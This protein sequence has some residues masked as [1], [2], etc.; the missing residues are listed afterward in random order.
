MGKILFTVLFCISAL[1]VQNDD[2]YATIKGKL[3]PS[4][5]LSADSVYLFILQE[6]EYALA[7]SCAIDENRM[8]SLRACGKMSPDVNAYLIVPPRSYL[9]ELGQGEDIYIEIDSETR[10]SHPFAQ[11]ASINN[12][13]AHRIETAKEILARKADLEDS[14]AAPGLSE[15]EIQALRR[16]WEALEYE[17][18]VGQHLK[19]AAVTR[20]PVSY[21]AIISVLSGETGG[22]PRISES[23]VDSL[24]RD[25]KQRFPDNRR[26]QQYPDAQPSP[27]ASE[28]S[29]RAFL[30]MRE[31]TSRNP[32]N[33]G[34]SEHTA[35]ATA[36]IVPYRVSDLVSPFTLAGLNE[37]HVSLDSLTTDYV[38]IDFW[39]GWCIPCRLEVPHLK[40]VL[41]K[42]GDH[43][44]IYAISL[45]NSLGAWKSAIR[46][47]RSEMFTHVYLGN[48]N[49]EAAA[50][51]LKQFGITAIPA[52][53][54]LDKDRRIIA[55][56]LR[57]EALERK[58]EGFCIIGIGTIR[59][60]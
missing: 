44:T 30:R 34:T 17:R 39:A 19:A 5:L 48:F 24:I 56:N 52:N 37:E 41:Q 20:R 8:F 16:E 6:N 14:L 1:F 25:M 28:A 27:P 42:Y 58:I 54:L 26:V 12:E 60:M 31:L 10:S 53:F 35:A 49:E 9:L 46:E 36:E 18:T 45:D 50:P 33:R 7:D 57:G 29:K 59:R 47:D 23:A 32:G 55:T 2:P 11:G 22:A 4:F 21:G 3:N 15:P 38:F 51:L 43:L 13:M 40:T